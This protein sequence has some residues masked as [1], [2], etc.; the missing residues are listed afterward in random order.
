M[1]TA[2]VFLRTPDGEAS[3]ELIKYYRPS[4]ERDIRQALANTPTIRH[5]AFVVQD[6]E[7]IVAK[8][9]KQGQE[10]IGEIQAYETSY[11]LCYVRGP[12][13]II[14]ELAEPIN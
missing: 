10:I 1:E 13:G 3:L 11:K 7:A 9:K 14:L 12:E 5:I 4:A 6:I 2:H 8:L